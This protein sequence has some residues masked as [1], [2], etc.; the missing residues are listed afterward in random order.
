MEKCVNMPSLKNNHF[1]F[2]NLLRVP[3]SDMN[4]FLVEPFVIIVSF[5]AHSVPNTSA[6]EMKAAK[7]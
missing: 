2:F 4:N 6:I 1:C 3:I 7:C 5:Q